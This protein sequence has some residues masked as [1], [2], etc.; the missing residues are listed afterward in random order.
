[1]K[2]HI[3]IFLKLCLIIIIFFAFISCD[4][5]TPPVNDQANEIDNYDT[6]DQPF[7]HQKQEENSWCLHAA[8]SAT[9]DYHGFDYSQSFLDTKITNEDG[10]GYGTKLVNLVNSEIPGYGAKYVYIPLSKIKELINIHDLPVIV[11]Q[12]NNSSDDPKK[13]GHARVV[14]GYSEDHVKVSDPADGK[15]HNIDEDEFLSLSIFGG[16]TNPNQTLS[17][18]IYP[19]DL[20]LELPPSAYKGD[21]ERDCFNVNSEPIIN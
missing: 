14:I 7:P 19:N 1:M 8:G 18:V 16:N 17:I 3:K 15:E 12:R 2:G 13:P 11:F 10:Y 9:L 5:I 20:S 21:E 6:L 4:G